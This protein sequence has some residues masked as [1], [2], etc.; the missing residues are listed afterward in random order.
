MQAN[1]HNV[2]KMSPCTA[3]QANVYISLDDAARAE[4][5]WAPGE[6]LV[7]CR[8]DALRWRIILNCQQH[9]HVGCGRARQH[10]KEQAKANESQGLL[11]SPLTNMW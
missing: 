6:V 5:Q 3:C 9:L 2:P 1:R 4:L 10:W 7:G 8:G 11:T